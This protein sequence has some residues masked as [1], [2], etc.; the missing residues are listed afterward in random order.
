MAH[1][2]SSDRELLFHAGAVLGM[3]TELLQYRPLRHPDSRSVHEAWHWD[4]L[5]A[6]LRTAIRL[7]GPRIPL[8]RG[9]AQA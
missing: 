7:A 3:P 6:R 5:R 8:Q 9:R 2:V 1:L 4:L